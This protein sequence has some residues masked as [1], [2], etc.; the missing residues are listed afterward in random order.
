MKIIFLFSTSG[1]RALL[2]GSRVLLVLGF[3][4][5]SLTAAAQNYSR[6]CKASE[7]VFIPDGTYKGTFEGAMTSHFS[8]EGFTIDHNLNI[9]GPFTLTVNRDTASTLT[10]EMAM[11][12]RMTG[13]GEDVS[14]NAPFDEK[15]PMKLRSMGLDWFA[16]NADAS[17][18]GTMTA[19][20]PDFSMQTPFAGSSQAVLDFHAEHADCQNADGRLRIELVEQA[21]DTLRAQGAKVT[22]VPFKWRMTRTEDVSERV[23]RLREELNQSPPAGLVRTRDAEA[24][25][26]GEIGDR[27]M[28]DGCLRTV[29]DGHVVQVYQRWAMDDTARLRSYNGDLPGFNGYLHQAL[30]TDRALSR[31]GLDT[32]SQQVHERLWDAIEGALSRMLHRMAK[33]AAPPVDVLRE[34]RDAELL[35]AVSPGLR[36]ECMGAIKKQAAGWAEVEYQDYLRARAAAKGASEPQARKSAQAVM[37]EAFRRTAAAEKEC[38]VLGAA[39]KHRVLDIPPA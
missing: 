5:S 39:T 21:V 1:I 9:Q 28:N 36:E 25:R 7:E 8:Q 14:L 20:T 29:W 31:L 16:A 23:R 2:R 26:L 35:G 13:G 12:F 37:E 33:T 32:C 30:S 24:T 11:A 6:H 34:L 17:Y 22:M 18:A 38:A 3:L 27:V 10:G 15:R 4:L 19:T